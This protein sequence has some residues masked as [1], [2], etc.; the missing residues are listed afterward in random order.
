M[1]NRRDPDILIAFKSVG[2]MNDYGLIS[3]NSGKGV[4]A[5]SVV[6]G[7]RSLSFHDLSVGEALAPR[8]SEAGRTVEGASFPRR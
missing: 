7:G 8:F 1:N 6:T 4:D 5:F 2:V 3:I